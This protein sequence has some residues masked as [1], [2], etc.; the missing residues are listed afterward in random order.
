MRDEK[1]RQGADFVWGSEN[2]AETST[3]LVNAITTD[4]DDS[5]SVTDPT[6]TVESNLESV[7]ESSDYNFFDDA[8]DN[9]LYIGYITIGLNFIFLIM[10]I[11][12]IIVK[13]CIQ[14]R[15]KSVMDYLKFLK[16]QN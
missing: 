12:W 9:E 2:D 3:S 16:R 8:S 6:E 14:N 13:C 11:I 1:S 4:V 5:S 10:L 7:T 15:D